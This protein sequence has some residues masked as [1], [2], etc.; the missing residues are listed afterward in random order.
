VEGADGYGE[1]KEQEERCGEEKVMEE[2]DAFS[3]A[4]N[5]SEDVSRPGE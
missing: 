5:G 1:H 4:W 3:P 2:Q